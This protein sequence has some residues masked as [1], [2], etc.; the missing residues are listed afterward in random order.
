VQ[1]TNDAKGDLIEFLKS[2]TDEEMVL[3]AR[4]TDPGY[5]P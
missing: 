4:W 1:L 5:S 3:D 2:F